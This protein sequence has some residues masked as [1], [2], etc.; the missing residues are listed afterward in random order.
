MKVNEILVEEAS[1]PT[2]D[3]KFPIAFKAMEDKQLYKRS[4]TRFESIIPTIKACLDAGEI[5][6]NQFDDVKRSI[7]QFVEDAF[8]AALNEKYFY[9]GKYQELPADLR[10]LDSIYEARLIPSYIK[11]L[12]KNSN[13]NHPM[14]KEA[15]ALAEE[16]LPLASIVDWLKNHKVLA[17][18]KR[19]EIKDAKEE[20]DKKYT[21]HKDTKKLFDLLKKTVETIEND[22]YKSQLVGLVRVVDNFKEKIKEGDS[23]YLE[24]YKKSPYAKSIIQSVVERHA[25][26]R[27]TMRRGEAN[28]FE[29]VKDY[30]EILDKTA[31]RSAADIIDHFVH[32]NTGKLSVIMYNKNNLKKVEVKNVRLGRGAVECD[33]LCEFD[34]GSSFTANSSVVYAIY[35]LGNWFYRYPTLFKNVV[36]PDGKKLPGATEQKMDEIFAIAK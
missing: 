15:L 2:F 4:V 21:N 35:K 3:G 8:K 22:L 6:S 25:S 18:A 12:S 36:M 34:D 16:L 32:K 11:K 31:K 17:S 9:A 24:I 14:Y 10:D 20:Y 19:K 27:V 1:T 23:D 33:V 29:L 28:K 30:M 13:K 5:I 26:Q 7:N